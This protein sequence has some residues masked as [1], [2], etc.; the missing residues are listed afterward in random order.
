MYSCQLGMMWVYWQEYWTSYQQ[1]D[2]ITNQFCDL[3]QD[4]SSVVLKCDTCKMNIFI[5]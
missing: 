2:L 5:T 1:T 4:F 3:E